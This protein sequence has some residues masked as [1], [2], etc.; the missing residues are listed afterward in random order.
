MGCAQR[1]PFVNWWRVPANHRSEESPKFRTPE[2]Q[3]G[4]KVSKFP[5]PVRVRTLVD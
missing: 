1:A 5:E 4:D 2:V 3:G